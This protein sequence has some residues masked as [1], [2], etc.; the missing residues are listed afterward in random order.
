M[1]QCNEF[2][3][4]RLLTSEQND[5]FPVKE[6]QK[7][8]SERRWWGI[9]AA[10]Y[11][12]VLA[13]NTAVQSSGRKHKGISFCGKGEWRL[14][15]HGQRSTTDRTERA[16]KVRKAMYVWCAWEQGASSRAC[17]GQKNTVSDEQ[18][19]MR[20]EAA[21]WMGFSRM[22]KKKKLKY[23]IHDLTTWLFSDKNNF[24]QGCKNWRRRRMTNKN[25]IKNERAYLR[26]GQ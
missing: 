6:Q 11:S 12:R 2:D 26:K 14:G 5:Q 9:S 25:R 19:K 8:D 7:Q 23:S 21:F 13:L 16:L 24:F 18:V 20:F 17:T 15:N 4:Q 3:W 1:K 10:I 22:L